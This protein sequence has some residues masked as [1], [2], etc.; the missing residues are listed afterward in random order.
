MS[1]AR[2][3]QASFIGSEGDG[4]SGSPIP[5]SQGTHSAHA[6]FLLWQ[7]SSISSHRCRRHGRVRRFLFFIFPCNSDQRESEVV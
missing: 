3:E 6:A 2:Q 7:R 5:E 1:L 4:D